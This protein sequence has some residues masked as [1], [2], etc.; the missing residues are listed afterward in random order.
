MHFLYR[1]G[2]DDNWLVESK[3]PQ[4]C[5]EHQLQNHTTS[6]HQPQS[7]QSNKTSV[8]GV[9]AHVPEGPDE[10]GQV[11]V[12]GC[13]GEID[14]ESEVLEVSPCDN[15]VPPWDL[16]HLNGETESDQAL[17][18]LW[19]LCRE[20]LYDKNNEESLR[21]RGHRRPHRKIAG[22]DV[23]KGVVSVDLSGPHPKSYAG[24]KY[25]VVVCAHL[26]EGRDLSFVRGV[27]NK[28]AATVT[29]ALC[30]VLVQ[31][32]SL[33][34]GEQL[35]FRIHSDQ[36]REFTAKLA[37]DRLKTFNHFRTFSVPYSHQSNGRVEQLID[38]LK[39][40]TASFLLQGQVDIRFWDEVMVRAAKLRRMRQLRIPIP[41]DLPMP[42]DYVLARKPAD[43]LPDFEDRTERGMFLGLTDHVANGS[44]IAV[45][46]GDRAVV[47]YCRLPI[48]INQVKPRWRVV[49]N[50]TSEESIWV[51]DRGEVAWNAPPVGEVLTVEQKQGSEIMSPRNVM[52]NLKQL[53]DKTRTPESTREIFGLFGHGL[54]IQRDATLPEIRDAPLE[55]EIRAS[56]A[57]VAEPLACHE[58]YVQL[59]SEEEQ[60]IE[61]S[62]RML[63]L[64]A[65]KQL[66]VETVSNDVLMSGSEASI[67][68]WIGSLESELGN[69]DTKAVWRECH[70]SKVR[71]A[72]GLKSTDYVPPPLPMKLVLTKKPLLEGGDVKPLAKEAI[73]KGINDTDLSGMPA[74]MLAELAELAAFKA[75]CRIVV[76]GNFEQDPGS[77][78]SSQNVDAD[79]LRY[80]VHSWASHRTWTGFAFDISAA[81]LNSWLP[82]GHKITMKP[83]GILVK[84]GYFDQDTLLIP[85]KSL[86]GLKRAPRDWEEERGLKMND[87]VL[88]GRDGDAH[89]DLVLRAHPDIPGLWSVI[90]VDGE[91]LLGYTTMFV[92]DGLCIGDPDAMMRVLQYVLEVWSATV[93]GCMGWELPET[94]GRDDMTISRVDEF[95]FLGLR[96]TLNKDGIC[97]DQHRWLAQELHRRGL[98]QL[99]G[100][101]SL[102]SLDDAPQEPVDKNEDY[103][104]QLRE[105]QSDIGSLMW[106]AMRT[107]PDVQAAVSMC[108]CLAVVCP[109]Y[110][111][112]KLKAIWRYVRKTMWLSLH[113]VGSKSTVIT[114]YSD[115][116]FAAQGSRS[117]TG[118]VLK[119]GS[120]VVSWRSVRQKLTAWS[121][122]EGE[123][124]AAATGLQDA[125]RLKEVVDQLTGLAH[126]IEMVCDNSSAVTLLTNP[127][128]NRV[129]WRTRHFALRASWIRDQIATQ[130]VTIRHEAG[131]TLVADSLTKVLARNRLQFMRNLLMLY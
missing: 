75:K 95:V 36:G 30:D 16:E 88:E 100:S 106:A 104:R 26:D 61:D 45:K 129:T 80:L 117:R 33:A 72:L 97:L 102:P 44:K 120:D 130:P 9:G 42:G 92:D 87:K 116:S 83:P 17:Q 13:R 49:S 14:P 101:P 82:K 96:I 107:R 7:T 109:G 126:T 66:T 10:K 50:P 24:N 71:E 64:L 127:T 39:S 128:F 105:C 57:A 3:R 51:S 94:L 112:Q 41:K 60:S 55:P 131:E 46:R 54:L 119:I 1:L 122:C 86:Y 114:A 93:Q 113:F 15:P 90:S 56:V 12:Q 5:S 69:M 76:C 78:L 77:D 8:V 98:A 43:V 110:V 21:A 29:D 6:T 28:E 68:K 35:T 67:K 53:L 37:Q 34:G 11:A 118:V 40:S 91:K 63:A 47:R 81:F 22:A 99:G 20:G 59:S 19:K 25:A 125:L 23:E 65:E 70:K 31:L 4:S 48:L 84:L 123:S 52:E 38:T 73:P 32:V 58:R 74:T 111:L 79:T 108:A 124:D 27:A 103:T 62:E 85:D 2:V 121:V 18:D 89:G 115:C